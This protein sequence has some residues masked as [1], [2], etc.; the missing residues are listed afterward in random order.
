MPENKR[1]LLVDDKPDLII[2]DRMLFHL[3]HG[4]GG[5]HM[6]NIKGFAL[7]E[8]IMIIVLLGILAIVAMPKY[9]DLQSDAKIAAEQGV[10]GAVRAGIHTYFAKNKAFPATLDAAKVAACSSAN[11]CFTAVV[12]QG[13]VQADWTKTGSNTYRGPTDA[14]YTYTAATGEFK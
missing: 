10:V 11:T 3:D 8:L 13:V 7:I 12:S 14:T 5:K 4:K 9:F 1:I 2:L 6:R